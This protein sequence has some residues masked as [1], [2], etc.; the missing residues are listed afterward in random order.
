[1]EQHQPAA[2]QLDRG[3]VYESLK[4]RHNVAI[5]IYYYYYYLLGLCQIGGYHYL[6][7][8]EYE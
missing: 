5:Q 7:E 2:T 1:M 4:L 3:S 6:A 8:Y